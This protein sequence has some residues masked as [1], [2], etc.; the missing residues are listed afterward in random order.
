LYEHVT[1]HLGFLHS[2]DEYKVMALASYGKP[3]FAKDFSDI[4]RIGAI[5]GNTPSPISG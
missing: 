2:S 1:A 3:E 4:I 5:T